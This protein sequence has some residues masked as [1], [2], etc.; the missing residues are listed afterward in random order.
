LSTATTSS[1]PSWLRSP[2]A[3]AKAKELP[4]S[5]VVSLSVGYVCARALPATAAASKERN[6]AVR[7]RNDWGDGKRMPFFRGSARRSDGFLNYQ[8]WIPHPF[9]ALSKIICAHMLPSAK[10]PS[11]I[12]W[13]AM[14]EIDADFAPASLHARR[15]GDGLSL[16]RER[17]ERLR[18]AP[19]LEPG[20]RTQPAQRKRRVIEAVQSHQAR[21]GHVGVGQQHET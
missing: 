18:D 17:D 5:S 7:R 3:S 8:R 12:M 10:A 15:A 4:V 20:A 6:G 13:A 19:S 2:T 14:G 9:R 11:R 16:E 1:S 21:S